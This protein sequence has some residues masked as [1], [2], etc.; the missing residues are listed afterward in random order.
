MEL[1]MFKIDIQLLRANMASFNKFLKDE[2]VQWSKERENKDQFFTAYFSY[3]SI[4]QLDEGVLR[5]LIHILWA[6]NAWTNKD[7]LLEEMLKSGIKNIRGAFRFLL[8]S[9]KSINERFDHVRKNVRMMGPTGISE[10]LIHHDHNSY[11]IYSSRVKTSLISLG[12]PQDIVPKYNQI[13]GKQY[14][15][16]CEVAKEALKQISQE[17][18]EINDFFSL[19][20]LLFYMSALSIPKQGKPI[21]TND[22]DHDLVIEQVIKLGDGLGFD[23][24]KEFTVTKGCRLD[25]IWKS[26]IANLGTI[27]YAFEVHRK[28]SRDSAILNLQRAKRDPSIQKVII[29]SSDDELERFKEEIKSLDENF[30]NSVGYFNVDDLQTALEHLESMKDIL[31][32]LGLLNTESMIL[33]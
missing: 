12:I 19:D 9:D 10:M 28:G 1:N 29:V 4:T 18:S 16:F 20:Y 33:T 25:A 27:T 8:F 13:S 17:F 6:F 31:K 2:G 23:V 3:K 15:A 7:Y 22:F 24:K 5:D 30:R 11:P 14:Q 21:I 32:T 26:R